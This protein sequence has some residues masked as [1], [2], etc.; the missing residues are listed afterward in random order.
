MNHKLG[1]IYRSVG[2]ILGENMAATRLE[3]EI[4]D[5]KTVRV[6]DIQRLAEE[7]WSELRTAGTP[8]YVSAKGAHIDVTILPDT[9]DEALS[10]QATAASVDLATISVVVGTLAPAAG[11]A[12][13]DI[14]KHVMLPQI[15]MRWGDVAIR[16]MQREKAAQKKADAKAIADDVG[17]KTTPKKAGV[18]AAPKKAGAK[19]V[20]KK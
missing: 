13:W 9:I 14:W 3:Y 15:R 2:A 11:K 10:I 17:A 12:A 18:R 19:K 4:L 16:E 5:I 8:A 1:N 20:H 6:I 7:I